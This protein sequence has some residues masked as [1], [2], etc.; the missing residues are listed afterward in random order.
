M[1]LEVFYLNLVTLF[2]TRFNLY[3]MQ[4][5]AESTVI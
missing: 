2:H 3:K 4:L 5:E 1:Q